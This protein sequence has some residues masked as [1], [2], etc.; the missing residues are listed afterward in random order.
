MLVCNSL[1]P[2]ILLLKRAGNKFIFLIIV[3]VLMNIGW[4]F[5]WFVV[6][7]IS[8]HRDYTPSELDL[9][10]SLLPYDTKTY[11]LR[12][13]ILGVLVLLVGQVIARVQRDK[14]QAR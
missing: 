5:E 14:S 1:V 13:L 12:G 4:L 11:L 9:K 2:F 6:I 8:L 10:G 7:V 3:S